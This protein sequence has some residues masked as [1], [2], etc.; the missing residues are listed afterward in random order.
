MLFF[1]LKKKEKR[2]GHPGSIVRIQIKKLF[3]SFWNL[4]V[5]HVDRLDVYKQKSN[6]I[7]SLNSTWPPKSKM[8][9]KMVAVLYFPP[10]ASQLYLP[11]KVATQNT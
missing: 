7:P 9:A 1:Y 10:M 6:Q 3:T 5:M 8:A 2:K 11:T 4:I